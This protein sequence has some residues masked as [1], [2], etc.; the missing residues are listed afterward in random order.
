LGR[1]QIPGIGAAEDQARAVRRRP[2]RRWSDTG[3]ATPVER[4]REASAA[5]RSVPADASSSTSLRRPR[6]L[7]QK[8]LRGRHR[9]ARARDRRTMPPAKMRSTTTLRPRCPQARSVVLRILSCSNSSVGIGGR[10]RIASLGF[11]GRAHLIGRD[12]GDRAAV[13][14]CRAGNGSSR[15]CATSRSDTS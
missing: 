8:Y 4:W 11:P 14:A 3:R 15:P 1:P 9:Q 13:G 5:R 12:A 10:Y 6:L 2:R 7:R